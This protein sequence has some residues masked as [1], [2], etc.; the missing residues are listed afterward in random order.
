MNNQ[1]EFIVQKYK[2]EM[3]A[4]LI[5]SKETQKYEF[6]RKERKEEEDENR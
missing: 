3:T 4:K 2:T 5:Y 6:K 1:L